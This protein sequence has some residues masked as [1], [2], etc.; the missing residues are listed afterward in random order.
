VYSPGRSNPSPI[1]D[2]PQQQ[3]NATDADD[4][5]TVLGGGSIVIH[6]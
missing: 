1:E 4:P 3:L 6:R 2:T 5:T